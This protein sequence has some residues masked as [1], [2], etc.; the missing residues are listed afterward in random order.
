[1]TREHEKAAYMGRITAALTHEM[2]NVLATMRES[3]GLLEDMLL[4]S[5][6]DFPKRD[7]FE[8]SLARISGQAKRGMDICAA[9]SRLAHGPDA[10]VATIDAA[11]WLDYFV[12][13]CGRFAR[14]KNI[15][16]AHGITP[17][18]IS[19]S[20]DPVRFQMVL[21]HVMDAL[22][23]TL[24]ASS[25]VTLTGEKSD[26][27]VVV[28]FVVSGCDMPDLTSDLLIAQAADCLGEMGGSVQSDSQIRQIETFFP[29]EI[30]S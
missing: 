7:V 26:R 25:T 17:A 14:L 5:K 20:T 4:L 15:S 28:R 10:P 2:R 13:V 8:K 6:E 16:L 3:G 9:L 22:L 23:A 29:F 12:F 27:G 11:E 1:M 24:P 30:A 21:F 19:F 18:G